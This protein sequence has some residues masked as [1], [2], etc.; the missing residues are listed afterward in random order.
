M[1]GLYHITPKESKNGKTGPMYVT[2][3]PDSTC[4]DEC[5]FKKADGETFGCYGDGGPLCMH[6]RKVSRGERGD[7][8]DV[9][10]SK[11]KALP[12]GTTVR[13]SQA[14]DQPGENDEIDREMF[15]EMVESCAHLDAYSYTHKPVLGDSEIEKSNREMIKFAN[16]N[17]FTMNLSANNLAHADRLAALDIGP[18]F[19]VLPHDTDP[20]MKRTRTPG[21]LP[22]VMCPADKDRGITCKKCRLCL[23]ADRRVVAGAIA[24]GSGKKKAS[25]AAR[26]Y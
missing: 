26:N 5:P 12:A 16:D 6:W 10:C 23:K 14:G 3:M 21:G 11:L 24:H 4:P 25:R 8:F 19:V 2:T 15:A 17:G 20:A 18:V 22:V 9:F 7:T 13:G 1:S